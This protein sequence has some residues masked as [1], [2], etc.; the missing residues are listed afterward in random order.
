MPLY[1]LEPFRVREAGRLR[2][3]SSG[4]GEAAPQRGVL[5]RRSHGVWCGWT[6]AG[7]PELI[8]DSDSYSATT[9][10]KLT[11]RSHRSGNSG[12]AHS[13][14]IIHSYSLL[15]PRKS[16]SSGPPSREVNTP[17]P[18]YTEVRYSYKGSCH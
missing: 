16:V 17:L 5:S 12:R 3:P 11:V 1:K 15:F 8:K 13:G 7:R 14:R 4:G 9:A 2:G 6:C 10:S 18:E